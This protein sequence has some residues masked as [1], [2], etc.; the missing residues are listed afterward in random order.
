MKIEEIQKQIIGNQITLKVVPGASR[1]ELVMEN[2]QLKLFLK[3][4]PEKGKANLA[5]VKYFKKEFKLNVE[6]VK[7]KTCRN[8]VL[9]IL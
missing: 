2:E 4:Q 7:G 1:T 6:V 3:N 5:L 8:K 9:R